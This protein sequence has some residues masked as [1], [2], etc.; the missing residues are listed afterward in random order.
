MPSG[1][2]DDRAR[3][4]SGKKG[5]APAADAEDSPAMLRWNAYEL[6]RL[7]NSNAGKLPGEA[8]VA[9]RRVTDTLREVIDTS[10]V[11]EL[12]I[13]AVVTVKGVL[14]D[15]LPTTLRSYLAL[16]AGVVNTPRPSGHSPSQSLVEQ[17]DSLRLAGTQ[18]LSAV[19]DQDADAL[20]AQGRFLQAK[21]TGS[22]LD[23]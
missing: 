7:I 4:P 20:L 16:D 23:L 8:V 3:T 17:I 10:E 13:Y 2:G 1:A 21:F 19:R 22:D 9:A 14:N 6:N 12:D 18:L 11:R 5:V 15:Y